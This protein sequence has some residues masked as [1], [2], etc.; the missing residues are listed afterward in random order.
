[1]SEMTTEHVVW[2]AVD[3]V[4]CEKKII[5]ATKPQRYKEFNVGFWAAY[6]AVGYFLQK[7]TIEKLIGRKLMWQ[8]G[9]VEYRGD[10]A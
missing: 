10:S 9:P 2:L 3:G 7:G 4:G 1:M 6:P 8:D 5:S